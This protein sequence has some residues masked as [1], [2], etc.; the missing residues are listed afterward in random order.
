[1]ELKRLS[2]SQVLLITNHGDEILYS[3]E[4]PIAGFKLG[5]GFFKN[6]NWSEKIEYL[7]GIDDVT[8]LTSHQIIA[9]F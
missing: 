8:L 3:Q 6:R 4:E 1:V 2:A 7:K 9:L 5:L